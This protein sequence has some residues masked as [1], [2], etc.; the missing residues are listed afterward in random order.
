MSG[1]RKSYSS[2]LKAK[3]VLEAIKEEKTSEELGSQYKIHPSLIR[4]WK[5]QLKENL[6]NMFTSGKNREEREKEELVEM[7]YREL[8][9]LKLEY[10]WLKKKLG[11]E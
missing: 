3:I 2:A 6:P 5:S 11:A 8:G 9:K 7:L 1:M 4:R 10:E